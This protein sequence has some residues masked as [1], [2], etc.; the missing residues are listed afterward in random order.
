MHALVEEKRDE[1]AAL[2]VKFGARRLE[3][4]GSAVEA[5][6]TI[7]DLDFLVDFEPSSS[8]G[9]GDRYFGLLE[10]LESLFDMKVDLVESGAMKN[11]Y[12]IRRVNESRRLLY[13][14]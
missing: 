12:F 1:L 9:R 14:A 3:L 11:P 2:C 13:A 4:F 5:Q 8:E 7:G 6:G 10:A